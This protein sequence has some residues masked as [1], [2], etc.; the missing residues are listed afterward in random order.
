VDIKEIFVE[1]STKKLYTTEQSEQLIME[2]LDVLPPEIAKKKA[3][4][5]GKG[6]INAAISAYLFEYLSSYN[7]PNHFVRKL[8]ATSLLVKKLEM[9]PIRLMIWNIATQSLAKRL[10]IKDGTILETPVLELYLKNH[11]LKNLMINDYHTYALG[12]CDRAEMNTI[13]RIGTKVN[14]VLKS[15]FARKKLNLAYFYLE[16]G[17][18][19]NQILLADEM[20]PDTFTVWEVTEEG[21]LDRKAF[22]LSEETAKTFYTKVKERILK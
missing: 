11:K 14:A 8:D 16:F 10:G 17:R 13:V 22:L 1:G 9:V 15:F 5:K 12:L 6:A 20:S 4:V 3:S 2:F 21:K 18:S 7:V 19:S